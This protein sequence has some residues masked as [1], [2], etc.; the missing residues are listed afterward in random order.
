VWNQSTGTPAAPG[1]D[2]SVVGDPPSRSGSNFTYARVSRRAPPMSTA[3]SATVTVNFFLGDYGLGN[4]FVS[5]GSETVT[6][7]AGDMTQI[8][9]AHS[10]TVPVGASSHL[11]LAV[12][13]DGPDG[14]TFAPPGVAGIAPGPANPFILNDNNKAQRNLQDTIGTAGG[15]ELIAMIGNAERARRLLRLR[16]KVP[17]GVR[18]SGMIDVVGG[19]KSEITN[20]ARIEI[21]ELAP[22]EVRWLRFRATSLAGIDK[23]TPIDLFEDTNPPANGFT[24]LLHRDSLEKVARRNLVNFADVL[25]RLAQIENNALAKKQAQLALHAS[26][27]PSKATYAAYLLK[28]RVAIREIIA[29]HRRWSRGKDL[30]DIEAATKDLWS[31]IDQKNVDLAAV[32]NTALIERLDAHLTALLRAR[33]TTY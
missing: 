33:G 16:V 1:P 22:G 12:Q 14:D 25:S 3:P 13:I 5:I 32:A 2:G 10:W 17:Q 21:G 6:F 24:I 8:T 18:I 27:K 28:N 23:P 11:C 26:I 4:P 19:R 30:F 15:T 29:A 7:T 31:A 20:D 9:P